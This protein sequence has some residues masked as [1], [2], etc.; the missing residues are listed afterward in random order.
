MQ[1]GRRPKNS[2]LGLGEPDGVLAEVVRGV[3]LSEEGVTDDLKGEQS[4]VAGCQRCFP[5][6][7][8]LK[9][10]SKEGLAYPDGTERSRDVETLEGGDAGAGD[11]ESVAAKQRARE[12]AMSGQALSIK[13]S[14]ERRR[15]GEERGLTQKS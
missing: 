13:T 7:K 5:N 8:D 2:L 14:G 9:S 3:V 12:K 15:R 6:G 11:L 10:K 1:E 4:A